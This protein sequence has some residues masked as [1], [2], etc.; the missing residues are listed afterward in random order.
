MTDLELATAVAAGDRSAL[1]EFI[2]RYHP[3]VFRYMVSLVRRVEDAEDLAMEA[4]LTAQRKA[5]TFKGNSSLR[6]W[7]HRIAY[8]EFTHWKRRQR[9]T[10]GLSQNL[11]SPGRPFADID[12]AEALRSGLALLPEKLS[13]PFILHEISDL[14]LAEVATIL[15]LPI[16]TV[17]TRLFQ[18]RERLRE[19]LTP[20]A[21]VGYVPVLES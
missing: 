13:Q 7:I 2:G 10:L 11:T 6:T 1:L 14:P 15:N 3:S 21:E 20:L 18:A 12:D 4:M 8:H 16:G 19:L 17:K 9:P 5:K